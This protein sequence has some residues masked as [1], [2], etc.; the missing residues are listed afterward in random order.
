MSCN[1]SDH[2]K[3]VDNC[4]IF[5]LIVIYAASSLTLTLVTP[6]IFFGTCLALVFMTLPDPEVGHSYCRFLLLG[7]I[8]RHEELL[9]FVILLLY[10][11]YCSFILNATGNIFFSTCLALMFTTLPESARNRPKLL[12]IFLLSYIGDTR[13]L[14]YLSSSCFLFVKDDNSLLSFS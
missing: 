13:N 8:V 11:C 14:C 1:P 2:H 6:N 9:L 12:H 3:V 7:Y 4:S 10:F 5:I